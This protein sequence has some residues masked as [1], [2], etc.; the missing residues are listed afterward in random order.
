M[1]LMKNKIML[2]LLVLASISYANTTR[3]RAPLK[4][5]IFFSRDR[6]RI[7]E[8]SF[9]N[10]KG[11]EGAQIT[12]AWKR[13]EHGNPGEY[14]FSE[15]EEDL[16]FLQS[17]GK[18]LWI[19]LQD[20]SF[21]TATKLVPKYMLKDPA[22]N[23]GVHP[24]YVI[25]NGKPVIEGWVARRW[26]AAVAT[27][28][29]DLLR[30]LGEKFDGKIEGINLPE[31]SI[32][33]G[34]DGSPIPPGFTYDGYRDAIMANMKVLKESFPNSVALQYANFMPNDKG[35]KDLYDYAEKI[36]IGVGG[37]DILVN[38]KAQMMNSYPMI[39]AMSGKVITGM[40]VQDG[41]YAILNV[42]TGK[43]VTLPEIIDFATNYLKLD[44]IF[45]CME[46]PYYSK[47]V[48][49]YLQTLKK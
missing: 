30:A 48:L 1:K 12:Y 46:E 6:E 29:H 39:R 33:V 44:Y 4:N 38:R 25:R 47:K 17:K 13:L 19:Q 20:V 23:G 3:A 11:A 40:A 41:N 16:H 36:G 28:W 42:K 2:L 34:E 45:W 22:Y 49:P 24:Q 9:Y 35:L 31:S 15:I 37:P 5:Y 7:H 32:G 21:D 14:D 26:D 43:K 27:R 18:K 8:P 10:N